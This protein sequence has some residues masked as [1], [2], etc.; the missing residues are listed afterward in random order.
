[1]PRSLEGAEQEK[2]R[3]AA[4]HAGIKL[5]R[6]ELLVADID[7]SP[8]EAVRAGTDDAT[9]ERYA[10]A[11]QKQ[12][13]K[14][15]PGTALPPVDVYAGPTRNYLA[16]GGHRCKATVRAGHLKVQCNVWQCE[17]DD[18]AF[19]RAL[20]HAAGAN[21]KHGLPRRPD[22]KRAAVRSVI[23]RPEYEATS[24]SELARVCVVGHVLV[25]QVR[26]EMSAAGELKGQATAQSRGYKKDAVLRGGTKGTDAAGKLIPAGTPPEPVARPAPPSPAAE[27]WRLTPVEELDLPDE[28]LAAC[29]RDKIGT[30]GD[31]QRKLA[32]G[33]TL[34]LD[35][36]TLA[37]LVDLIDTHAGTRTPPDHHPVERP[38]P[39]PEPVTLKDRRGRVV[40][41][42]VVKSFADVP[43]G[44]KVDRPYC[45]CP[46]VNEAG[47]HT[48]GG[49]CKLCRGRRWLTEAQFY[50]LTPA[51]K[52]V[53][54]GREPDTREVTD[55][56]RAI[57]AMNHA[58]KALAM[59]RD[60][61]FG[62]LAT[63]HRDPFL[64]AAKRHKFAFAGHEKLKDG[65]AI[66]APQTVAESYSW[67]VL[68]QLNAVL[69]TV[70]D[71]FRRQQ[72]DRSNIDRPAE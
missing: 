70:E 12:D 1:M 45:V 6:T 57:A 69:A 40:P 32:G 38:A 39:A 56:E 35:A 48:Y 59:F 20:V 55:D 14:D 44:V 64:S 10:D 23:A 17:T 15:E 13:D 43:D 29:R 62:L 5:T 50:D 8:A 60:A 33:E 19:R 21:E 36:D 42:A 58:R 18:D 71:G 46:H 30:A 28:V 22:D 7:Q 47:E 34:D 26:E 61:A 72:L 25:R 54:D 51:L 66:N 2:R 68:E 16:D 3:K 53:A 52:A 31:L 4:Y 41:P 49:T 27:P 9:V 65:P 11:R 63:P 67:P 37:G 24:D